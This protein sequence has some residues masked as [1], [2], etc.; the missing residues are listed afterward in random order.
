[1]LQRAV[2]CNKNLLNTTFSKDIC[3]LWLG[4]TMVK[5]LFGR[6]RSEYENGM[7]ISTFK[8]ECLRVT[9]K[10]PGKTR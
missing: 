9:H 10:A 2:V 5:G 3:A 7:S 6:F 8:L 1:M 4:S